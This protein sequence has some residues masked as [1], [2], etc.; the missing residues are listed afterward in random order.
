M[1]SEPVSLVFDPSLSDLPRLR[2]LEV[3][4]DLIVPYS[5][6]VN[7]DYPLIMHEWL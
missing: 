4:F 2:C 5:L 6:T 1:V 7:D 3:G